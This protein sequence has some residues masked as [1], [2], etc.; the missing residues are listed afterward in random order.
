ML[1]SRN[2]IGAT[3]QPAIAP[4]AAARPQPSASIQP[5]RTPTRRDEVG[6]NAAARIASPSLVWRKNR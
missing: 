3:M 2:T 5:T 1:G 4:I 6:L